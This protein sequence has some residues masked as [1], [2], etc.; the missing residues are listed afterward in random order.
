VD[1]I[2]CIIILKG[3]FLS[4]SLNVNSVIVYCRIDNT[5]CQ[6]MGNDSQD[7][8]LTH[9]ITLAFLFS[10]EK[11]KDDFIFQSKKS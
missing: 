6:Y 8:C 2:E 3:L 1:T 5:I 4:E 11:R 9:F 10:T 7:G